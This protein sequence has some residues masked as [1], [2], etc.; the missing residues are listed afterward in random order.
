MHTDI[1]IDI[2]TQQY[3]KTK[4]SLSPTQATDG[5]NEEWR[6][7]TKIDYTNSKLNKHKK[8]TNINTDMVIEQDNGNEQN[9]CPQNDRR[10]K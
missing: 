3:N 4:Q 5:G 9:A 10:R 2:V 1:N 8:D 6:F 7:A